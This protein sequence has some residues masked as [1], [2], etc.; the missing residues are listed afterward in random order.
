MFPESNET[1]FWS[2]SFHLQNSGILLNRWTKG[3]TPMK[4]NFYILQKQKWISKINIFESRNFPMFYCVRKNEFSILVF[5]SSLAIILSPCNYVFFSD[6]TLSG[7]RGFTV[8]QDL[9]YLYHTFFIWIPVIIFFS[10]SR[11]IR[12]EITPLVVTDSISPL[13]YF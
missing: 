7:K 5:S 8:F 12:T 3:G 6:F 11:K 1:K 9:S 2:H 4:M 13:F 10:F